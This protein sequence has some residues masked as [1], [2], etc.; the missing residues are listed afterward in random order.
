[1]TTM[2]GSNLTGVIDIVDPT[3]ACNPL[4][5]IPTSGSYTPNG[6][7]INEKLLVCSYKECFEYEGNAW[8]QLGDEFN[9]SRRF[10]GSAVIRGMYGHP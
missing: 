10:A 2:G 8:S 5:E 7:V 3:R 1:M 9:P 6:G 4:Q